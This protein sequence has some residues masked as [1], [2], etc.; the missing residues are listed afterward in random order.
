MKKSLFKNKIIVT[1]I[2]SLLLANSHFAGAFF[3]DID[4]KIK[5]VDDLGN[6][7]TGWRWIDTNNDNICECY[8]FGADGG[9]VT[10]SKIRG[11]DVN[12]A[13][14]WVVNGYVQKIYKSTGKPLTEINGTYLSEDTNKYIVIGTTS[15]TK[16]INATKK[17][18]LALIKEDNDK[19]EDKKKQNSLRPTATF[20]PPKEGFILSRGVT[21]KLNR[22]APVA[23]ISSYGVI[24]DTLK[25][26]DIIYLSASESIVIGRD[27]R[28]FV[29]SSNKY[30]ESVKNVKIYGGDIWD[31]CICLQ[32]NGASVKFNL[33]EAGKNYKANYFTFEVA[34]Q[35]H[36]ESTADT[37]CGVELYLNGHSITCY[38]EFCDGEPEIVEEWLDD[39]ETTMEL[40]AIVTG[41]A[42]GRK[43]YIRNIR[44]R[45]L[46]DTTEK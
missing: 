26:D 43:I 38:D 20:V 13:G 17:D 29:S 23:T 14:Q 6:I 37:Y 25:E 16:R 40:K 12:E 15:G 34:H 28:K 22:K 8:R 33:T 24:N 41:D 31:D 36:G 35:T 30:T 39:G 45:Q 1:I 5:Y 9:L 32:G 42:P 7:A 18:I 11:R 21:T 4:G 44:F 27:A 19:L 2:F 46:K 10:K 3:L